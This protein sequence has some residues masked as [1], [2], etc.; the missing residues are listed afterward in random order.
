MRNIMAVEDRRKIAVGHR[1]AALIPGMGYITCLIT[2]LL[3]AFQHQ[4][5]YNI[6]CSD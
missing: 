1:P 4:F 2:Y 5:R 3:L 6:L